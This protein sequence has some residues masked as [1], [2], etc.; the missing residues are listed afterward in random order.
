MKRSYP[1][2]ER[3]ALVAMNEKG[4]RIEC[5]GTVIGVGE[6]GGPYVR[7]D[8]PAFRSPPKVELIER[9]IQDS[10]KGVSYEGEIA[11]AILIPS[12]LWV[13]S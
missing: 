4:T 3:I 8:S 7:I 9:L 2:G 1:V 13:S 6:K 10:S 12:F 5:I 11:G